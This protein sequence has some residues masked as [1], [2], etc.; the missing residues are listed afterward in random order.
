MSAPHLG[1]TS[2]AWDI[3]LFIQHTK[4]DPIASETLQATGKPAIAASSE[5]MYS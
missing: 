2:Q 4:L 1:V 5:Y 3:A